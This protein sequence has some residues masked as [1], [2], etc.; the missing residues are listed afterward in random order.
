MVAEIFAGM[1]GFSAMLNAAKTI[2]DMDNA[3][4]RNTAVLALQGQIF[5]S[6]E[7]YATLRTKVSE[8]E[9]ELARFETWESDKQRYELKPHGEGGALAYALKEGVEPPEP[10]H[11]LCPDCY[12]QRKR[13]I[14]QTERYDGGR[15]I[16]L[17]CHVCDWRGFTWGSA[18]DGSGRRRG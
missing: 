8:L 1:S 7:E 10:P 4:A 5:A 9:K 18:T 17:V 14:L 16:A 6:Q 12:Q 2:R 11:S 3:V 15:A 13:S